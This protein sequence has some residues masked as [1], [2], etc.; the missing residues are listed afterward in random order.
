MPHSTVLQ[1]IIQ[2]DAI[3][4][5]EKR[6]RI[7]YSVIVDG[8]VIMKINLEKQLPDQLQRCCL[9]VEKGEKASAQPGATL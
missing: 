6:N 2:E 4:L 1:A 5:A 3:S 7:Y 8:R 9:E